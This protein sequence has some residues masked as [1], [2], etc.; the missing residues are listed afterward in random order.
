[1]K[2]LNLGV[3]CSVSGGLELA[4]EEAK[5]LGI[6][7]MQ[8]FTR[9]QRQWKAKPIAA[10]EKTAYNQ[11]AKASAIKY[12]FS[13]CSYLIN[14]AAEVPDNREKSITALTDEV[15]RCTELGLQYCVLHPGAAGSQDFGT[16]ISKIADGINEVIAA[17]PESKV[18]IL[19]ENTAGQGTSVG[20]SFENLREIY[21]QVDSKRVGFC[22]DTCHAFAAGYDIRTNSGAD[23]TMDA[24]DKILGLKN[25]KVFHLNDSKGDLGTH[26]DRHDHIGK[27]KLGI[28][29]FQ[30]IMKRFSA[31][32]K[33]IETPK[34]DD[35]DQVNLELLRSLA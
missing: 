32:P 8:I 12:S 30:Y 23:D 10:E 34:E 17:T 29:P 3:H 1:M 16:A 20:G 18:L 2:N 11:A 21:Q 5:I 22:F 35:W 28:V 4:F 19:L 24:F 7:A 6:D 27:G 26:L 33:V 31:V 14:L 9:N 15:I 25:L 13:H